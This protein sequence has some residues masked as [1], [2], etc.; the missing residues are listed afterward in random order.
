MS[1]RPPVSQRPTAR[2][3]AEAAGVSI[4]AVSRTFTEGASVSAKTRERVL[5]AAAALGY[6]PNQLAR[7]LMTGRTELIGLVS[8]HFANPT[9]MEVFDLFTRELQA[10]GLR[11]LLANLGEGEDG[12]AALDMLRQYSVDAVLIATSAPPAGFAASC[13][14]AGLPVLHVFGR[15]G[16]SSPVPVATV[17]NVAGGGLV[18]D[19]MR[20]RGLRRLAFLGGSAHDAS[21]IDREKGFADAARKLLRQTIHAGNYTHEHGRLA[22]HA[23]LDR[24]DDLD[25][26][27]CADDV[28]AMGAIDACRE[29]GVRVPADVSIVGFDDMPLAAWASYSL[30]TVRQPIHDMV[31][32]A[33]DRIVAW[34]E[35]P[36]AVPRSKLF[37]CELVTRTSLR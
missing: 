15:A 29:R 20:E 3:V 27:F 17:D 24:D 2:D 28:L 8:N 23:L 14:A 36:D 34:M 11:P 30:T 21:T 6:R 19:A 1:F 32:H 35:H 31:L 7:S 5:E 10:R 25:G 16:R 4:S 33:I 9:F 26:V 13:R 12:K 37:P 18:A 22:M